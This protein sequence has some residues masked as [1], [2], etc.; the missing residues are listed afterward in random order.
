MIVA[1]CEGFFMCV[2]GPGGEVDVAILFKRCV[3]IN[4]ELWYFFVKD[5]GGGN[6]TCVQ[7]MVVDKDELTV[8][9]QQM[10]CILCIAYELYVVLFLWMKVPE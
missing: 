1:L 8:W 6:Y 3:Y 9:I 4:I 2:V 5:I 10:I 7:Y